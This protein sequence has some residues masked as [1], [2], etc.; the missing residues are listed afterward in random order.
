MRQTGVTKRQIRELLSSKLNR[1]ISEVERAKGGLINDVFFVKAGG[2][3]LVLRVSPNEGPGHPGFEGERWA[4]EEC[5]K[6][7][8][9]VPK[10]V[11]FGQIKAS[12][13]KPCQYLLITK[14]PGEPLLSSLPKKIAY[15]LNPEEKERLKDL[16]EEAGGVLKK[17]H[18]IRPRGFGNLGVGGEGTYS[19]WREFLEGKYKTDNLVGYLTGRRLI[20]KKTGEKLKKV[21]TSEK[22]R[23]ELASPALLHGDFYYDHIFVH[24]GKISGTIDFEDCLGG[25]PLWDLA[26]WELYEELGVNLKNAKS[27]FDGHQE[28]LSTEERRKMTF[29][30]IYQALPLIWW[31][32][33]ERREWGRWIRARRLLSVL[34]KNLK[35]WD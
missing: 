2:E 35:E 28:T 33:E 16:V 7:G 34:K 22:N 32:L 14:I 6:A 18:Q 4:L 29:Y 23:L 21:L 1:E 20:T 24:E 19:T 31:W 15:F 9:P 5:S 8:I 25:D 13:P 10:V 30:K 27:L 17:V 26:R 12:L 11:G 3:E